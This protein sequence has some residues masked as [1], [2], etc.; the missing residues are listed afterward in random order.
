LGLTICKRLVDLMHGDIQVTSEPGAGST[1]VVTLPIERVDMLPMSVEPD[2][3]GVTCILVGAHES[4]ADILAYLEHAGARVTLAS[5]VSTAIEAATGVSTPVF[6]HRGSIEKEVVSSQRDAFAN[7]VNARHLVLD[8]DRRGAARCSSKDLVTAGGLLLRRSE[9]L[10]AVAVATGRL[11]SD[12]D[13]EGRS[14][15][16]LELRTTPM[17]V[18]QARAQGRLLLVAEDDEVNQQV[19]L[20]QL[21]MLG[22]AAEIADDG[23]AA[24]DMW[25]AGDYALLL[26]DLHM[27]SL[28]GCALAEAIRRAEAIR[29]AGARHR[30]PIL[31]LTANALRGE[32]TQALAAGMDEYLTKPLQLRMLGEALEKWMPRKEAPA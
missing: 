1:F 23:Q 2:L 28:D 11:S 25:I 17:T 13:Q 24:L 6:V 12:A 20:R 5:D 16:L 8:P 10:R 31:A 19:I 26:T 9:L 7:V 3:D 4:D 32:A 21:E 14:H 29:P 27:P 15:A 30:M 22:Y 18:E